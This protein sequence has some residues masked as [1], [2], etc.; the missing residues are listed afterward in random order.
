MSEQSKNTSSRPERTG[1]I[2][3]H[4]KGGLY[5]IT[6]LAVHTETKEVMVIYKNIDDPIVSWCRPLDMFR[7]PV[8][9][10]KYPDVEQKMRF[11]RI[12]VI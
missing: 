7:S 2:Y 5:V 4:F 6:D 8:D 3:R 9:K 10:E 11:E 1:D 12:E